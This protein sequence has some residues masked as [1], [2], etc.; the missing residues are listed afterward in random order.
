[1]LAEVAVGRIRPLVAL[2]EMPGPTARCIETYR[3][4]ECTMLMRFE[5][6][7]EFD[8]LTEELWGNGRRRA[9]HG[10]SMDAYRDGDRFYVHFDLPG[11]DPD[12]IDVTVE[13]NVLD[14]SA[15]RAWERKDE[16]EWVVAERYQGAFE[17]QLFLGD[18]LDA[19]HIEANYENGVL[20]LTIPVAE[21]AKPRKIQVES[22]GNRTA[23]NT[24]SHAA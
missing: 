14:V 11:V 19:D 24:D 10:M 5:P 15:K 22:G 7:R 21:R 16:Q 17:R 20:T 18:T 4:E 8:R 2:F 1:M 23:I 12:S 3:E 13:D 6:F 9:F